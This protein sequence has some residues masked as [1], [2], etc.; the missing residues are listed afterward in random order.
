MIEEEIMVIDDAEG[1]V[2]CRYGITAH[3]H[4]G[5]GIVYAET[6][7]ENYD[8]YPVLFEFQEPFFED[9]ARCIPRGFISIIYE[10][11]FIGVHN[12]TSL[13]DDNPAGKVDLPDLESGKSMIRAGFF[14]RPG[15]R[16]YSSHE[17][18]HDHSVKKLKI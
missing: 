11:F 18:V 1:Q 3:P 17:M 9:C 4:V 5:I 13:P 7:E 6:Q 12:I 15:C 16:N 8:K 14:I 2:S 10:G